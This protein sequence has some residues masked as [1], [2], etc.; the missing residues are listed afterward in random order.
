MKTKPIKEILPL[1]ID[2]ELSADLILC[3]DTLI[4][5]VNYATHILKWDIQKKREGKDF[6][7]PSIFF[8]NIIELADSISIL[9]KKSSID[10]GK[11]VLRSL[12]ENC[13]GL[14]YLLDKHE[15]QRSHSFM[16]W[17]TKKEIKYYKQFI[18]DHPSNAELKARLKKDNLGISLDQFYDLDEI[19]RILRKKAE[20]LKKPKF[21]DVSLEFERSHRIKKNPEW[22]SLFNGPKN[23]QALAEHFNKHIEY[24]F[25]YRK[26]SEN[27]HATDV[28]KAFAKISKDQAQIIQIRDFQH[29]KDLF[30]HT[31][32]YLLLSMNEIINKRL[33]ERRNEF[34][35]WYSAFKPMEI[36]AREK[37][38]I[39]YKK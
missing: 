19:K 13:L 2:K 24:H 4:E 6:S 11:I 34:L 28:T 20:L 37:F 3:T 31:C 22:F 17:K 26:Y 21:K 14:L 18:S 29:Y 10:P 8:R 27:V 39:R 25:F 12:F 38:T 16:V 33:P 5:A 15:D 32:N 35:I 1:E 36:E 30:T 23:I 9:L 7:I